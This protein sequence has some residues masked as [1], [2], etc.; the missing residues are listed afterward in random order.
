MTKH[1]ETGHNEKVLRQLNKR[2]PP[3]VSNPIALTFLNFANCR[4]SPR[5]RIE[6]RVIKHSRLS[7]DT[8]YSVS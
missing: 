1:A 3:K 8:R 2:N 5:F 4:S 7:Y 6:A